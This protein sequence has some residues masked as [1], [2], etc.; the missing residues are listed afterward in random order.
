MDLVPQNARFSVYTKEEKNILKK[1][2]TLFSDILG[3]SKNVVC[4]NPGNTQERIW[5]WSY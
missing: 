4:S 5:R 2:K 3:S 1:K